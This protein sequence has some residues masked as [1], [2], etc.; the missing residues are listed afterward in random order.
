MRKQLAAGLLACTTGAAWAGVDRAAVPVSDLRA[1]LNGVVAG[2][3]R[4][5]QHYARELAALPHRNGR[6]TVLPTLTVIAGKLGDGRCVYQLRVESWMLDPSQDGGPSEPRGEPTGG[7]STLKQTACD[8]LVQEVLAVADYE[9][10]SLQRRVVQGAARA[11]NHGRDAVVAAVRAQAAEPALAAD[12]TLLQARTLASRVNLRAAPALDAPVRS[13]LAPSTLLELQRTTHRDWYALR[14][15]RGFIHVRA[16]QS[17]P[18]AATSTQT[19]L[20]ARLRDAYVA[21][22]E[23]PSLNARVLSRLKPNADVR[24][25][26][27]AQDGWHRL[28]DQPGFIPATALASGARGGIAVVA[29]AGTGLSR[30]Q[31]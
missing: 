6:E 14:D 20:R 22:R 30:L 29:G 23:G 25:L 31:P 3:T 19:V 1:F 28:A 27:D 26:A 11:N 10:G 9:V 18:V 4:S 7:R 5:P 21:V 15:G 17:T 2:E 16:L 8:A 13:V 24:L 12:T